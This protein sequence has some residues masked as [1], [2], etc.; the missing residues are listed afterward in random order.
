MVDHA[1][2][3]QGLYGATLGGEEVTNPRAWLAVVTYRRAIDELRARPA[4]E[5]PLP[6]G[7]F[8]ERDVDED[9]DERDRL[10]TLLQGMRAQLDL[11]E[12]EA[13][14][15]CYLHGYSRSEA[16]RRMGVSE[17]RMRKLM[18][19]SKGR[20]GVSAKVGELV[21]T[22]RQG[23]FCEQ[24][25]SLMRALAFGVLDPQGE[26]YRLAV[27]HRRGCPACRSYVRA[28]RGAAVVLPP[29]LTVPGAPFGISGLGHHGGAAPA[30]TGS[31]LSASAATGGGAGA[32]GGWALGGAGVKLAAGCLIAAGVGAGCLAIGSHHSGLERSGRAPSANL[33]P[34]PRAASPA[35]VAPASAF[36]RGEHRHTALAAGS[37]APA[38]RTPAPSPSG[39]REFS[40]EQPTAAAPRDRRPAARLAGAGAPAPSAHEGSGAAAREFSPG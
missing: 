22:I 38:T 2:A 10:R 6:A 36:R 24:Q 11:R 30:S 25:A 7:A 26:R 40:L 17:T 23:A 39:S 33:A 15:L 14:A 32:S 12:R 13:A 16:A 3:W 20:A 35:V 8:V 27:A 31:P 21:E 28:L 29:V 9:L 19:G 4:G 1:S 34:A 5:E 18:D 37:R